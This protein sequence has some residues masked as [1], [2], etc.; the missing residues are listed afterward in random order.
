MHAEHRDG[1]PQRGGPAT[2]GGVLGAALDYELVRPVEDDWATLG[3]T[4][5]TGPRLSIQLS[6]R[7]APEIPHSHLDLYA[8]DAA[9]QAAE[10]ERLLAL[11]AERVDWPLYPKAAR[12]FE[13]LADPDGN[14]FCV[15][16][17]SHP[18]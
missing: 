15:I 1:R 9:D 10:I 11:G 16:N 17:T 14:R 13:V 12:D 8:G 7:V 5:D 3:P 4:T 2:S 6:D 18:G